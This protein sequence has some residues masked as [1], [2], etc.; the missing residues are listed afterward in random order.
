MKT[1]LARA[2]FL[3]PLR[4]G[5]DRIEDGYVVAENGRIAECGPWTPAVEARWKPA[6]ETGEASALGSAPGGV[7]ARLDGVLLP[8]FVKAHGHDTEPPIIGIAKDTP[9]T[10]WLD[11][12]VNLFTGFLEA[13][14]KR[15]E[16]ELGESPYNVVYRK[17]RLDDIAYGIT[18]N[19]VHH[20]NHG[21][22][23]ALE[24]A[25]ENHRAGTRMI[26]ALGSQDRHY[27]KNILDTPAA[28]L[29]RLDRAVEDTASFAR[30]TVIPGP[31][32]FFSNSPDML[33]A[34][35][36]WARKRDT[37]VHIHS[38]EEP[39]TTAWFRRTYG[40]T[41]VEYGR[42]VG[43]LD[44][45]T[46]L[47]HQV[48]CTETDLDILVETGAMVVHN[49]LANAILG[50]GMP[51]VMEMIRRNVPLAISTDGSG[52][53]DNQNIISA[54]RL[55]SQFQRAFHRDP[56]LLP[57]GDVL[58]RITRRPARMIGVD[59]GRLVPGAQA[60]FILLDTT[61]PNLV[62]T[63]LET[64]LE[65]MIWSANGVEIRY[66]V[67]GGDVLLDDYRHTTLDK[68]DTLE[69][70][71]RIADAFSDYRKDVEVR[72]ETG[73]SGAPPA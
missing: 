2:R 29:A 37:L 18:T 45:K 16:T 35:K 60:D 66:V 36:E 70:M 30:F 51:P 55:A 12:A 32:Q 24:I 44:G 3:L 10:E 69:K 38:S 48:N 65:N 33:K 41:P 47:A 50:S 7:P 72:R 21:K 17:A 4:G 59:A 42:S 13:S 28:A 26:A 52:S 14:Q 5:E 61:W 46:L 15:L 68:P 23:H 67:V 25:Q 1:L 64:C 20:C 27:H 58:D 73:A 43:F 11:T 57:A 63:R 40:L 6:L 8:G 39:E 53:A 54:A 56:T 62:P 49:P 34:L 19:L 22:Y 31:D 9:L 71:E